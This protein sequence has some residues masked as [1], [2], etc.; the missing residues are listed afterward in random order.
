MLQ[1]FQM[2]ST[3]ITCEKKDVASQAFAGGSV[4]LKISGPTMVKIFHKEQRS[5]SQFP[6]SLC[7]SR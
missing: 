2:I 7:I 5:R 1:F 6:H 3:F 4:N